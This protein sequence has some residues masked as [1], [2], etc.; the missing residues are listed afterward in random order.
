[1]RDQGK[2]ITE[3]YDFLENNKQ[4]FLHY[5]TVNDLHHLHRGGRVSKITA[6]VGTLLGI[7]PVLYVSPEGKLIKI[8]VAKGRHK[9][10][11]NLVEKM[12]AKIVNP[13]QTIFISHGDCLEDAQFV[14]DLI[15]QEL[16]IKD[17]MIN[18][19]GPVV[20]SHSGPGTVALF[21]RGKDRIE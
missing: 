1:M 7:K 13:D 10:L 5:F 6:I 8:G 9:A 19:I 4:S 20:G 16:G 18:F 11:K 17:I 15:T 3:I 14:A 2:T 21:F 12:K